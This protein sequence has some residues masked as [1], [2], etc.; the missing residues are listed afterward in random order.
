MPPS[1]MMFSGGEKNASRRSSGPSGDRIAVGVQPKQSRTQHAVPEAIRG[2][3]ERVADARVDVRDRSPGSG[4]Q[5]PFAQQ[6]RQ[7]L[8]V[9]DDLHLGADDAP[10]R[11]RRCRSPVPL[12]V[13]PARASSPSR[14]CSRTKSV[15]IAVS[16][17]CSFARTSPARKSVGLGPPAFARP[18]VLKGSRSPSVPRSMPVPSLVRRASAARSSEPYTFDRVDPRGDLVDLL[19]MIREIG[20]RRR[21]VDRTVEVDRDVAVAVGIEPGIAGR[22]GDGRGLGR[23][24]AVGQVDVVVEELAPLPQEVA[25]VVRV[26]HE[27]VLGVDG[28]ADLARARPVRSRHRRHTVAVV[29]GH[30]PSERGLGGS[31]L[32]VG[33][34][35]LAAVDRAVVDGFPRAALAVSR[36]VSLDAADRR[37]AVDLVPLPVVVRHGGHRHTQECNSHRESRGP[38]AVSV[39]V[40]VKH[41]DVASFEPLDP[42]CECAV[43]AGGWRGR[44]NPS[45][46]LRVCNGR[47]NGGTDP[48]K[49]VAILVASLGLVLGAKCPGP[50]RA[51][52]PV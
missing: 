9:G 29:G 2:R 44:V 13:S 21:V 10:A 8:V 51:G 33:L 5:R 17:T 28:V 49:L 23:V 12:R 32:G 30:D 37:D 45:E 38:A 43:Y 36:C 46:P 18:S 52:R 3:R 19:A 35:V 27:L 14:L 48:M 7:E 31:H 34:V 41:G 24:D 22:N 47:H 15:C 25:G 16:P 40:V 6:R 20:A 42:L 4:A 11:A 1:S 39:A 26:G 50:T